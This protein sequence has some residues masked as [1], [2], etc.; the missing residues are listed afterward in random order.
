M[1][2]TLRRL[3]REAGL[4][5]KQVAASLG[6]SYQQV[7]KYEKGISSL[8]AT[9]V[10]ILARLYNRPCAAFFE[11]DPVAAKTGED[12]MITRLYRQVASLQDRHMRRKIARVVT[13]LAS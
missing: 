4:T 5:Q 7:Q 11:E 9:A 3:R 12:M 2:H 13:I 1:G 10:P 6:V 8:A